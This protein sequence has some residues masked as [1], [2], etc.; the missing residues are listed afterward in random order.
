M[1]EY[2]EKFVKQTYAFLGH[3][4]QTEIRIICPKQKKIARSAEPYYI[5]HGFQLLGTLLRNRSNNCCS[6]VGLYRGR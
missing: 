3:E 5:R 1:E 2:D 4:K 6:G